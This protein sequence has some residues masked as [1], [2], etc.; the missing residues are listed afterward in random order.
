MSPRIPPARH[1]I[2]VFAERVPRGYRAGRSRPGV[3]VGEA[4]PEPV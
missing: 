3:V 1:R 2:T 4:R